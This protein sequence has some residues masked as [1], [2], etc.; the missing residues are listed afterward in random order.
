M[1]MRRKNQKYSITKM[2][3]WETTTAHQPSIS[4]TI[5]VKISTIAKAF[6]AK[7]LEI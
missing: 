5:V 7:Q 2:Q 6:W 4:P 1:N 3:Q